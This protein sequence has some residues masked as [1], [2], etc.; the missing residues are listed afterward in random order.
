MDKFLFLVGEGFK[1]LW[2]FK[3]TTLTSIFSVFM[4][5]YLIGILFTIGNNSQKLIVYLRSKYK[6]EVFYKQEISDTEAEKITKEIQKIPGVR[7]A[8]DINRA[9][10]A[11]IFKQQFGEDILSLLEVNPLPAS[12][13]VNISRTQNSSIDI[14]PII[15]QIQQI[16]AVDEVTFQGRLINRIEQYYDL[17]FKA[18]TGAAI[19]ILLVTISIIS[20]T[21]KLTCY[22]RA[23][24][25]KALKLV[26]AS[27]L[28]IKIPF[29]IDGVLQGLIGAILASMALYG[30]I[31]A[32]N[33][34]IASMTN[35]I[36]IS[37][38]MFIGI[39]L[40]VVAILIGMIG[41]SR[42]SGKLLK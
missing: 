8:T 27:N 40:M 11:R 7:S 34:F 33:H 12:C 9:N 10:A 21:I 31:Y 15:E 4:T 35:R 16:E 1:N 6:I 24:L 39:W 3:L 20:N 36:R 25:V 18:L 22:I 26:G 13:V 42:A 17:L 28:F 19:V 14:T 37:S 38:D 2:R 23:D 29:I 32:G 41:A 5:L 30:T